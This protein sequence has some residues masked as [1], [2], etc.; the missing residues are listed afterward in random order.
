M[1]KLFSLVVVGLALVATPAVAQTK[2]CRL[3][4]SEQRYAVQH[5][6]DLP[7][8][9]SVPASMVAEFFAAEA[10]RQ[11]S[12]PYGD[13][14]ADANAI[15]AELFRT[16]NWNADTAL[17]RTATFQFPVPTGFAVAPAPVARATPTTFA[18]AFGDSS[19]APTVEAPTPVV[20]APLAVQPL[21]A[22]IDG[23]DILRALNTL[24]NSDREIRSELAQISQTQLT[25]EQLTL[26][27]QLNAIP[28]LEAKLRNLPVSGEVQTSTLPVAQQAAV[29]QV[30][31]AQSLA[32]E[33]LDRETLDGM[34]IAYLPIIL[35]LVAAGVVRDRKLNARIALKANDEDLD[36]IGA[37]VQSVKGALE[38]KI[39]ALD[40]TGA[41]DDLKA[42]M[43]ATEEV[44]K[45]ISEQLDVYII[46]F[47]ADW[48]T[49]LAAATIGTTVG[50]EILFDG[51][52]TYAAEVEKISDDAVLVKTGVK[53]VP[54]AVNV[55]N[56]LTTVKR[57]CKKDNFRLTNRI[58]GLAAVA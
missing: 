21:P 52:A 57:A 3:V 5:I 9:S 50:L 19:P 12:D 58:G 34:T 38:A 31:A 25:P 54:N 15:R 29:Q 26:L 53:G 4:P 56:L 1:K 2:E 8:G 27:S 23:S 39:A 33:Y 55:S 49:K 30:I 7:A 35:L 11:R 14:N 18:S 13:C 17:D 36:A 20:A 28:D 45:N 37:L 42:R 6:P 41:I 24:R 10:L 43:T 51:T 16:N 48:E 40:V 44:T 47:E 46:E 22:R 32:E